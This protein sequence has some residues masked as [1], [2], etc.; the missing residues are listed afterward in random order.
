[1]RSRFGKRLA[2]PLLGL[3]VLATVWFMTSRARR[4]A[5]DAEP[6]RVVLRTV[7]NASGLALVRGG[8]E[9]LV[10][11]VDEVD[12]WEGGADPPPLVTLSD[13]ETGESVGGQWHVAA[14]GE[15]EALAVRDGKLAFPF[16]TGAQAVSVH[17]NDRNIS[18]VDEQVIR[19]LDEAASRIATGPFFYEFEGL[20]WHAGRWQLLCAVVRPDVR[21]TP[22]STVL[23]TR[24][25]FGPD[26]AFQ[27]LSPWFRDESGALYHDYAAALCV[28]GDDLAVVPGFF[29]AGVTLFDREGRAVRH[30]DLP[31]RRVEGVDYDAASER[32]FLVRECAEP[33]DR[34]SV[35]CA[36]GVVFGTPLWTFDV[37][38]SAL[39]PPSAAPPLGPE[40]PRFRR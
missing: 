6:N 20:E 21:E 22:S 16:K 5:A 32:L 35:A 23:I 31:T 3:V 33:D 19:R 12:E 37:P 17:W 38:R 40:P 24:L 25:W 13:P 14:F 10:A 28:V 11:T 26:G 15:V 27:R 4:G 36:P 39:L 34:S 1:M 29:G 30:L 9:L 2:L 7:S 8:G 18:L